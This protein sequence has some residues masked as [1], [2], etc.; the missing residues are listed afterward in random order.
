MHIF[1]INLPGDNVRREAME[2]QLQSLDLL[3]EILPAV[4]GKLLS[5]QE[6]ARDYDEKWFVRH[7][8]RPALPGEI[9]CALSHLKAYRLIKERNLTHA[10]ILEDDAWLNP[11]LPQL[12]KA[13]ERRH[14]SRNKD[15]FL[16][17][18]VSAMLDRNTESLWSTYRLGKIESAYCAHGY[19]V[20]NAAANALI[21]ALYPIRHVADCWG[22]LRRHDIVRMH[23]VYPTCITTDLSYETGT[24]PNLLA[25][26]KNSNPVR[27]LA[28]KFYRG[29]WWMYDHI[30]ARLHRGFKLS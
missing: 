9:G 16:L 28:R 4:R 21:D 27:R 3:Y 30:I 5:A 7:E 15:V 18:W 22:W 19:V 13:I 17:T 8:G 11:N 20:S 25:T 10:L 26:S 29:F 12:L 2:K 24:T 1:V 14:S 6:K 23:G